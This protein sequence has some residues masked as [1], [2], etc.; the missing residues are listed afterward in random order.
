ML[1]AF[2]S[3]REQPP[4]PVGCRTCSVFAPAHSHVK[5]QVCDQTTCIMNCTVTAL[6]TRRSGCSA[7]DALARADTSNTTSCH[8]MAARRQLHLQNTPTF[9]VTQGSNWTQ[10]NQ[11]FAESMNTLISTA[12]GTT[13][14][15]GGRV[16]RPLLSHSFGG[17]A[18]WVILLFPKEE[19]KPQAA[20]DGR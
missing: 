2:Q 18:G 12:K 7:C 16:Q 20:C 17:A 1:C 5:K 13:S 10:R 4:L 6:R 3:Y 8:F 14:Y 15:S 11:W 9:L 19:Q